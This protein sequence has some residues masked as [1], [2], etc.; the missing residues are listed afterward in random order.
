MQRFL[1][2]GIGYKKNDITLSLG[3]ERT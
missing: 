2:L 3:Y 1:K